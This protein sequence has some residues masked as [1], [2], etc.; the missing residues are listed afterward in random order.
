MIYD[1]HESIHFMFE[2]SGQVV[3]SQNAALLSQLRV[4]L[5]GDAGVP[6]YL[7]M[8]RAKIQVLLRGTQSGGEILELAFFMLE[9]CLQ[10][11]LGVGGLFCFKG[12]NQRENE[13]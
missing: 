1:D 3:V 9:S 11:S 13:G 2:D 7:P 6:S 8:L 5:L 4:A 10:I 12:S